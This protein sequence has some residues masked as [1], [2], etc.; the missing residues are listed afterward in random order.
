MKRRALS[1]FAITQVLMA[2][3]IAVALWLAYWP[4]RWGQLQDQVRSQNAAIKFIPSLKLQQ[5]LAGHTAAPVLLDVR[6]PEEFDVSHLPSARRVVMGAS[7]TENGLAGKEA[8]QVVV[9]D[10]VGFHAAAFANTLRLRGF[11]EVPVLDGAIFQG[12]NEGV[13]LVG[14]GG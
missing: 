3:I 14:P 1:P 6:S 13:T 7:L 5:W 9:Y 12:T 11:K 10:T 4:W 8:A 2:A